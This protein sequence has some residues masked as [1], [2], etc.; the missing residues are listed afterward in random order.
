M[1]KEKAVIRSGFGLNDLR[2]GQTEEHVRS[3]LGKPSRTIRRLTGSYFYVYNELG[4]DIDFGKKGGKIK[5]I[6]FYREGSQGHKGAQV[7][8]HRNI[9]PGDPGSKVLSSYGNPDK[10]GGALILP[11]GRYSGEWLFYKEGIQF[12]LSFD[13]R[14]NIISVCRPTKDRAQKPAVEKRQSSSNARISSAR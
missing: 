10:R 14:V 4:V 9:K 6:F 8:T 11:K 1:R 13:R 12:E 3:I 5:K 7:K 2:L